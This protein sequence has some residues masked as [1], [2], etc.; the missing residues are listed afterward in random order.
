MF[1]IKKSDYLMWK[2]KWGG[3][4]WLQTQTAREW[5]E[6][7]LKFMQGSSVSLDLLFHYEQIEN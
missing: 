6:Q 4:E 2:S 1:I 5:A 3:K 7:L